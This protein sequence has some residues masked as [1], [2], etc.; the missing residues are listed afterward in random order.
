MLLCPQHPPSTVLQSIHGV[1]ESSRQRSTLPRDQTWRSESRFLHRWPWNSSQSLQPSDPQFRDHCGTDSW[2]GRRASYWEI[3]AG[4]Y[5]MRLFPGKNHKFNLSISFKPR[6]TLPWA[7]TLNKPFHA[8]Q[9][10]HMQSHRCPPPSQPTSI[11]PATPCLKLVPWRNPL[12]SSVPLPLIIP[13]SQ[14]GWILRYQQV[15]NSRSR[16]VFNHT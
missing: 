5:G 4:K 11:P 15:F 6:S 14:S 16:V 1:R 7:F 13:T 9:S 12:F 10:H 2:N 3:L 8:D